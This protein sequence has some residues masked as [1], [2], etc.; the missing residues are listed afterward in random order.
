[1]LRPPA[2]LALLFLAQACAQAPRVPVKSEAGSAVAAFAQKNKGRRVGDGQCWALA[3]EAFKACGLRRPE[4]QLRVWGRE[5]KWRREPLQPGDIIEI[6]A[7]RFSD[8]TY[9]PSSHTMIVVRPLDGTRTRIAEQNF[10]GKLRVT[11][12]DMDLAG[13]RSGSLF[14]YRPAR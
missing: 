3:N 9:T 5:V 11:E 10:A 12:R 6:K 4:G 14:V 7:A 2:L 1:M 13:L 8:G